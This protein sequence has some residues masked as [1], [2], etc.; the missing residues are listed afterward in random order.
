MGGGA[1]AAYRV[2]PTL[3]LALVVNGCKMLALKTNLSGDALIYQIGP[4][5]TPA[6]LGK[7]GPY[8][9]VLVGGIKITHEQLYPEKK[10]EVLDA[11]KNLDPALAYT[12]HDQ[13]T[14]HEDSSGVALTV[15]TGVDYKLSDALA[16]RVASLEYL[17]SSVGR[18]GGM[19]YSNGLQV[20]TGVVLRLGTW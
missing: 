11:N 16:V 2:A 4:R 19:P 20:T 7:W 17:R 1:D 8:A 5:W 10:Q 13:Y 12:L 15:G 18:V 9:H 6:P 14:S 3:Q